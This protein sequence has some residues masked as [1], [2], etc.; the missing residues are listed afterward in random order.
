MAKTLIVN[1]TSQLGTHLTATGQDPEV[2]KSKFLEWKSGAPDDHYWFS[3]E[4]IGDFGLVHVHMIPMNEPEKR[5]KWDS[6]WSRHRKRRSDRYLLYADGG[7]QFGC[8]LIALIEDPGAHTLWSRA[9]KSQLSVFEKIADNF[10]HFRQIPASD[11]LK[12][13]PPYKG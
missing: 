4:V 3:R 6:D 1:V 9:Q 12:F 7:S 8:L 13:D 11:G 5:A 2:L 10:V